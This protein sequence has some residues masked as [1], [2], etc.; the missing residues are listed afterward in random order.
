MKYK[1][2]KQYSDDEIN[3][4]IES[5]NDEEIKLLPMSLGEYHTNLEYVQNFCIYLL[6]TSYNDEVRANAIL[7]LSYLARRFKKL[8]KKVIPYLQREKQNN[9]KFYERV[10]YSIEDINLFLNWS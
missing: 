4:I 2:L 6:E 5:H 3:R 1:A 10:E 9:K 8:D 7:G